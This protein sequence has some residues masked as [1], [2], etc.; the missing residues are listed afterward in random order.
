[1]IDKADSFPPLT[2]S[3]VKA[4]VDH[5]QG[6]A[7]SKLTSYEAI[8]QPLPSYEEALAIPNCLVKVLNGKCII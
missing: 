7:L 8:I 1:M 5:V 4:V 6:G 3:H 2:M